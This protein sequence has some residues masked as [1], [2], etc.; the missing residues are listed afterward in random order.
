ME[1]RRKP[2]ARHSRAR[3]FVVVCRIVFKGFE[4]R[5]VIGMG[6]IGVWADGQRWIRRDVVVYYP[7][8]GSNGCAIL[9]GLAKTNLI[10]SA[11]CGLICLPCNQDLI[12]G[13]KG[14]V[15][16]RLQIGQKRYLLGRYALGEAEGGKNS[17]RSGP[18]SF[19]GRFKF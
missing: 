14:P 8:R 13:G 9:G 16:A 4:N 18:E 3:H 19:Q 2:S 11:R 5:S 12:G 7:T 10:A 1:R 15:I 17:C 6:S